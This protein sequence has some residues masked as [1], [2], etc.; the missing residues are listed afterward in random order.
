MKQATYTV[1]EELTV[2]KNKLG[3][4]RKEAEMRKERLNNAYRSVFGT[5]RAEISCIKT[6]ARSEIDTLQKLTRTNMDSIKMKFNEII[7]K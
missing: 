4:V 3:L 5:V 6:S 7:L 1:N 2:T